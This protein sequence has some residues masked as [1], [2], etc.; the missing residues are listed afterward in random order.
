MEHLLGALRR[1]VAAG[2]A[3]GLAA[4]LWGYLL[5]EPVIDRAVRLESARLAATGQTGMHAEVFS[6]GTQHAGL[7]LASTATGTALGVLFAVVG[8]V[9]HRRDPPHRAWE[10]SMTLG[11][12]GFYALYVVPFLRYPANPPGVGDPATIGRRT[13]GYLMALVVG[14]LAATLAAQAAATL[15]ARGATT[16]PRQLAAAAVLAAGLALPFLLPADS[17]PLDVPAGLLW[18]FRLLSVGAAALLWGG[19]AVSYGLL[20]ERTLRR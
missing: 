14:L 19:L 4:G 2:C 8:A 11:G 10:R 1:G 20:E 17:D 5:A 9:L 3:G 13:A 16:A 7:V 6:R 18:T 15:R 12:A